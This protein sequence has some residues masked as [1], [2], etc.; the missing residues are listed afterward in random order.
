[1]KV[2]IIDPLDRRVLWEEHHPIWRVRAMARGAQEA[3]EFE[4]SS[5]TFDDV[6]RMS[7]RL[8]ADGYDV[9]LLAVAPFARDEGLIHITEWNGGAQGTASSR[10]KHTGGARNRRSGAGMV[11]RLAVPVLAALFVCAGFGGPAA[12]QEPAH[13]GVPT[14][15]VKRH[16]GS[17]HPTKLL[18]VMEENHSLSEMRSGM[19]YLWSL[20]KKYGYASD[21]TA[22]THPSLPNYL[23][24]AG[25]STF[26]VT[27]DDN[28]SAHPINA[29]SVFDSAVA[30]GETARVYAESMPSNCAL[31]NSLP[32]MVHH[33]PWAYF[34][35]GR[36][37]C[38]RYDVPESSLLSD[39]SHN[40]LPTAGMVIPNAC[41]DAHSC[42][43]ST[44]D[45]WLKAR[46]PTVLSSTDF[47]S[48]RLC[49]VVTADE[50]DK[51]S[52]NQVLTVVLD[53]NL[54]GTVVTTHLTHYSLS[55][56]YSQTLGTTPLANAKTAPDMRAAFGL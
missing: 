44:A 54:S 56:F 45:S 55:R 27:D 49:V 6:R 23:A 30:A 51:T 25:G 12:A 37:N 13:S 10:S 50:D 39:A 31:T 16:V 48:G 32:Y 7:A 35:P 34:T 36:S 1:V 20:A 40:R 52:G 47:T 43:L 24:I 19:P 18:V 4:V 17:S 26:G 15:Q 2:T 29:P 3:Q 38:D 33:N 8:E 53:A 14:L 42:S 5:A 11:L 9:E 46:L 22:I 41:D 21:Y 28:P